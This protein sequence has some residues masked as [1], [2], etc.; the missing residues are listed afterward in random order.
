MATDMRLDAPAVPLLRNG[1]RMD[2][3]EFERRWEAMPDLKNAELIEGV[4]YMAA[5]LSADHGTPHFDLIKLLG[6][7][8]MQTP[9]VTGSDNASVRFDKRN[10][11]Q[12]DILLRI[13]EALGGQSRISVD[14]YF[15][16]GPELIAE[17]ANTTKTLDLGDKKKVYQRHGVRE[18]IVWRVEDKVLAWFILRDGKYVAHQPDADGIFKSEVFPGLWLDAKALIARDSASLLQAAQLG[19]GSPEHAA[20][21]QE[22]ARRESATP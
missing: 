16:G 18:Y 1:D 19:I 15:E 2:R 4:V 9:Y 17:I 5:A 12:P 13:D 6:Y 3:E 11:P 22:L 10:M 21:V 8:E 20:F 14:R 7:Y